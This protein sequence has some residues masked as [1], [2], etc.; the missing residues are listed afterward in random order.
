[1]KKSTGLVWF[2]FYKPKTQKTEPNPNRI[3]TEPN[4]KKTEPNWEN[5]ANPVWTD[6]CSKK[7]KPVGLNRF[8]FLKKIQ[9][10]Y[11]FYK[12]QNKSKMIISNNCCFPIKIYLERKCFYFSCALN[13]YKFILKLFKRK[14][15]FIFF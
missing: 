5:R 12:N 13:G 9:F 4:R 1:L 2:W 15:Y 10:G 3:K 14:F 6:F 8:N 7:P 11:F